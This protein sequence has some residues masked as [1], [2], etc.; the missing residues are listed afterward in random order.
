MNPLQHHLR[1]LNRKR[2]NY[3]KI[4]D[5]LKEI[6]DF[7]KFY[8]NLAMLLPF[9]QALDEIAPAFINTAVDT[10]LIKI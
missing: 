2:K 10:L 5:L 8:R 3:C 9:V 1:V 4:Y 6:R 7:L